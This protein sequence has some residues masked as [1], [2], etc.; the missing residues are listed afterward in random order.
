MD[1]NS[2]KNKTINIR[3]D[4]ATPKKINR[5]SAEEDEILLNLIKNSSTPINWVQISTHFQNKSARQC[6]LKY[7]HINPILNKGRWS[8]DE[9][10]L[11]Y[12]LIEQYGKNWAKISEILKNRSCKQ[13]RDHFMYCSS[14]NHKFTDEDDN[15]IKQLY[16]EHG[17]KF[18][19]FASI[20]QGKTRESIKYRF[21]SKL[22]KE[23]NE[24]KQ[25][26]LK[27]KFVEN[28]KSEYDQLKLSSSNISELAVK[29]K[30]SIFGGSEIMDFKV[31]F[32]I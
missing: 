18:S 10:D 1:V 14:T 3:K 5:W 19:F 32:N 26:S 11:L 16:L 8:K 27:G 29:S 12:K 22:N 23:L 13:V 2:N 20:M 25:V 24:L 21:Y 28:N 7:R 31:S 17:S 6:Y 9:D 15:Q 30:E 4:K